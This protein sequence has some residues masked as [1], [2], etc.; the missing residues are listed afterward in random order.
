MLAFAESHRQ[1]RFEVCFGMEMYAGEG[2]W[3][4]EFRPPY[5]NSRGSR[6]QVP[7]NLAQSRV[8]TFFFPTS[9]KEPMPWLVIDLFLVLA[10]SK[11]NTFVDLHL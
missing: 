5:L 10:S 9:R 6:H 4:I 1:T 3:L 8:M 11:I 7:S 2:G